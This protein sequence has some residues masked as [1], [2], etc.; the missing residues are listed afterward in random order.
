M[1]NQSRLFLTACSESFLQ[2]HT[3]ISL[4]SGFSTC[5]LG[6]YHPGEAITFKQRQTR[7]EKWLNHIAGLEEIERVFF[8]P[9]WVPVQED[10]SQWYVDLSDSKYPV[11][12][13]YFFEEEPYCWFKIIISSSLAELVTDL[14]CGVDFESLVSKVH[15]GRLDIIYRELNIRNKKG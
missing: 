13:A 7:Q 12:S 4:L 14:E 6:R 11:Y 10:F 9:Y 5:Q 2:V 1:V 15:Q 3:G 8:K